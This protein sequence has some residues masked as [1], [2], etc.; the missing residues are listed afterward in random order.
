LKEIFT[1]EFIQK[2]NTTGKESIEEAIGNKFRNMRM[3][4]FL[5]LLSRQAHK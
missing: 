2:F 1:D 4:I 3:E 5:A